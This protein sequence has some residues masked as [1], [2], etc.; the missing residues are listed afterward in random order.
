MMRL[1]A[2][3]LACIRGG[4]PI[5]AGLS[6]AVRAGE[7]LA[8][9]GPNGAGKTSL[10]RLIAGLVRPSG[11]RLT[12]EGGDA[13]LSLPEQA[14]YLGHQDPLK[15]SLTVRENLDFW[16]RYFGASNEVGLALDAADLQSLAELPASYLSAGQ[17]RRLSFARLIAAPRPIWLLDEPTAMLDERANDWLRAVMTDHLTD[18]GIIIAATHEPLGVEV[19]HALHLDRSQLVHPEQSTSAS[20]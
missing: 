17:R 19:S 6:F 9:H 10:L 11:G 13:N 2:A 5:F 7:A 1:L 8:V 3:D 18:G 12:L 4:R 20:A 16:A 15:P 14:H